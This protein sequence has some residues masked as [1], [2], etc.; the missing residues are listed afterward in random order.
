MADA[1]AAADPNPAPGG[2]PAPASAPAA[3]PAPGGAAPAPAVP[4]AEPAPAPGAK[5]WNDEVAEIAGDDKAVRDQLGRFTSRAEALKA[6]PAL[7]G[8]LSKA[9]FRPG[10]DAKPED[11]AKFHRALGVPE[12]PEKYEVKLPDGLPEHVSPDALKPQIDEFLKVAHATG[13][14]PE[15]VNAAVNYQVGMLAQQD[16]AMAR[17]AEVVVDLFANRKEWEASLRSEWTG[18][19]YDDNIAA[20]V[21]GVQQFGGA[22]L[23][24]VLN[25][26]GLANHPAVIK[27]FARIGRQVA[28]G[29]FIPAAGSE[30]AATLEE[31]HARLT[32]EM[33]AALDAGDTGKVNA[34]SAKRTQISARLVGSAPVVGA[35]GRAF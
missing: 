2:A 29:Q 15:Q 17:A 26:S 35:N 32:R 18:K 27:A 10:K 21:H 11:V 24:E 9:I 14:T 5:S 23:S 1:S 30:T 31:E 33:H 4:P 13:M 3:D 6:I 20:A 22:E 25:E 8:Q 19:D 28:E 7:R 16:P 12:A 34:L